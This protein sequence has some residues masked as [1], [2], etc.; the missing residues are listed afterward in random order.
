MNYRHAVAGEHAA[1]ALL[2]FYRQGKKAAKRP[3]E[4][5]L[6]HLAA[7]QLLAWSKL[8]LLRRTP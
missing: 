5:N 8:R 2:A 4:K 7:S 3:T 1:E 6:Q